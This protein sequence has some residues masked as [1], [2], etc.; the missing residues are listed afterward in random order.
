MCHVGT[1]VRSLKDSRKKKKR[2]SQGEGGKKK[3]KKNHRATSKRGFARPKRH[4]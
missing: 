3:E 4:V 2:T 1:E